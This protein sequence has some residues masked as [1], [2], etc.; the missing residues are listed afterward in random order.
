MNLIASFLDRIEQ[1]SGLMT[2]NDKRVM[3]P[4]LAWQ[5]KEILEIQ[6]IEQLWDYLDELE[7][8]DPELQA[9]ME[10]YRRKPYA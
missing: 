9:F 1:K 4:L 6:L 8:F 3:R 5:K 10:E 2:H 7:A